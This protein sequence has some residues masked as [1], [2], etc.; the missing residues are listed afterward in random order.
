MMCVGIAISTSRGS[1]LSHVHKRKQE[2]ES[3]IQLTQSYLPAHTVPLLRA[4][5][6]VLCTHPILSFLRGPAPQR[7]YAM[8]VGSC[9]RI[10][11]G[12]M[13]HGLKVLRMCMHVYA[14]LLLWKQ[15]SSQAI[16][17]PLLFF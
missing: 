15:E 9:V 8:Y 5:L 17:A 7:Q 14:H 2:V 16:F 11:V 6:E 12:V 3:S 1:S 13:W 10:G 4:S